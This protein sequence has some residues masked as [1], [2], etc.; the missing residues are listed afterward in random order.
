MN[1]YQ[2]GYDPHNF[3]SHN[4]T[5]SQQFDSSEPYIP[6]V[7]ECHSCGMCMATCPTYRVTYKE[8]YS[9]RGRI[10]LIDRIINDGKLLTPVEHDALH[11]CTQCHSCETRCP[12]KMEYAKLYAQAHDKLALTNPV[13]NSWVVNLLLKNFSTQRW[14]Q[15]FAGIAIQMYQQSGLQWLMQLSKLLKGNLKQ[16]DNLLP[17]NHS[18]QPIPYYSRALTPARHGKVALFTGCLSNT[19]DTQTHN[20][21]I[22]LLTRLGYEVFVPKSQTCCGAMH[23]HNGDK[24]QA[25]RLAKQNLEAFSESR[26]NAV[27]FNASGCGA[28]LS[29]YQKLLDL[30]EQQPQ[31]K[32]IR[33]VTDILSFLEAIEWPDSPTFCISRLKVAVHEPCSQR[34]HL[35]NQQS[36][37]NLL[38]KIPGLEVI[39]LPGNT[40]CCGAGGTQMISHPEL[41]KP[42]ADEKVAALL[43]SGADILL[44]SNMSCALHLAAGV[45]DAGGDI[46]VIHPLQLLARQL[47]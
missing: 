47:V 15:N 35:Q 34:N 23:A 2:L 39:E 37:Y 1:D 40:I 4:I 44:S 26:V 12:S 11:S 20:D 30:D 33:S 3:S 13:E 16:L 8:D 42:M 28:F 25:I 7:N 41:A 43:A 24:Q 45:R 31:P 46:E 36:V 38:K 22:K 9:P 5:S 18:I 27:V 14:L 32:L 19:F 17:P 29:D 6:T 21:T 10:R